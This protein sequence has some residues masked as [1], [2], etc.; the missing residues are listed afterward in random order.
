LI[1]SRREIL[2]EL[3]P[4]SRY[5]CLPAECHVITRCR[6]CF[7]DYPQPMVFLWKR[8]TYVRVLGDLRH[9]HRP[10]LIPGA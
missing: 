8:A 2:I 9:S 10:H 3:M 7:Q 5:N 1:R 4:R 6:W